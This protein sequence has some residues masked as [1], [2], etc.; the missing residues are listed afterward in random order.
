MSNINILVEQALMEDEDSRQT[1]KYL[2]LPRS[3]SAQVDKNSEAQGDTSGYF[4]RQQLAGSVKT[5]F[6]STSGGHNDMAI[7]GSD[8]AYYTTPA[9]KAAIDNF[10]RTHGED[11]L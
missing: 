1:G 5:N 11:V 3:V 8:H 10:N 2:G 9:E 4:G 6:R 7:P